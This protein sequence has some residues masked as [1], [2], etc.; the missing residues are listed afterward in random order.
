MAQHAANLLAALVGDK[1]NTNAAILKAHNHVDEPDRKIEK[2]TRRLAFLSTPFQGAETASW[3]EIAR[4]LAD[5]LFD[6]N[7]DLLKDIRQNS[8]QLRTISEGFPEWL[9][10]REGETESRVEVIFFVEE[11]ATRNLGK[12]VTDESAHIKGY[13]LLTIRADHENM[14]KFGGEHDDNYRIVRDVLRRWVKE[15]KESLEEVK[16]PT[17]A[18]GGIST[19]FSGPNYGG[20]NSG[21]FNY[22]GSGNMS[23]GYQ[24]PK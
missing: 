19:T 13:K 7:K 20:I 5:L 24:A 3:A 1:D 14:C 17:E 9:R 4:R 11:L 2:S 23:L 21:Q 6:T 15:L 8:D 16:K 10:E 22:G 12:I 18:A